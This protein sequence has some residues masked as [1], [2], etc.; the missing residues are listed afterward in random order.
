MPNRHSKYRQ[1][2]KHIQTNV[3]QIQTK[4]YLVPGKTNLAD[5]LGIEA[6]APVVLVEYKNWQ[7]D[8]DKNPR[9]FQAKRH[10]FSGKKV[11]QIQ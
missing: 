6:H 10:I 9:Y 3:K 5:M 1:D 11:M 2:V 8:P 7:A 4:D